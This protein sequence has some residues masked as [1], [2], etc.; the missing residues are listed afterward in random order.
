L[1]TGTTAV[2]KSVAK[3][4]NTV[5]EQIGFSLEPLHIRGKGQA[6]ADSAVAEAKA[7]AKAAIAKAA[8]D[9]EA[10][11]IQPREKDRR[12]K[13]IIACPFFSLELA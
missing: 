3:L 5:G 4:I 7:K 13:G 10:Q 9:E 8:H 6:E 12:C 11:V 2:P 1:I